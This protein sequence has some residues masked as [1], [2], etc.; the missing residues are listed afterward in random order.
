VDDGPLEMFA[1]L[2]ADLDKRLCAWER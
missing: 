2:V 1:G